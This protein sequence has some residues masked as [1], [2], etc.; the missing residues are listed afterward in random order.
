MITLYLIDA[1]VIIRL[2]IGDDVPQKQRAE[3][4]FLGLEKKAGKGVVSLQVLGEVLWI[5]EKY[6]ALDRKL[7]VPS[8]AQ[9]LAN[10]S[11]EML[12][13]KKEFVL[14]VL[15]EYMLTRLDFADLYLAHTCQ[16]SELKLV[17]FDKQLAKRVQV[18]TL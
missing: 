15:R 14:D 11:F 7:F 13:V 12:E 3:R 17:T 16:Q 6:Y 18:K 5:L 2:L 1:N 4:F 8:I 10:R 9:L